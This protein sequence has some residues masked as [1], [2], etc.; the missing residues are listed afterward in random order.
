MTIRETTANPLPGGVTIAT[1]SA[2]GTIEDDDGVTVTVDGAS[3]TEGSTVT[4]TATLSAAVGSNV[5]LGWT[6]G[7]DDTAG[8]RQ[9]TAGT[10]Y[11]AVTS[12]SV[13]IDATQTEASF[14][15]ST[16]SDTATEGDETFKVTIRETTANPLPGGVTIVTASAIG[17]IQDDD[18]VTVSVAD[19][20]ATEGSTVT[21]KATLSGAVSSNVVLGWSTSADDTAG[22]RQATAGTDYTAVT[23]GSVT[24]DATQTEATFTVQTTSDT[25]TEGDETFK[26]TIRETTANPLPGGVTIATASA[27]GTIQDDD[28]VTVTVDGAS[29]T[30]GSTVTFKATLSAAVGSNVVLG[31]TTGADDTSGARQ[32]T[33]GTDYTAVTSGSVTI[34]ATQTEATFTVQTTQDTTTEGDETF[35]VTIRETTA[36]PLPGGVTIVTAS[37]VGTIQDD[38]GVTVSVAD[39]SATEGSTVT[40]KATLSAAV[41]SNVVLGWTTGADDTSG[42]RQATAGTDYTAVTSG[43]VTIVATQTEASFTV[44]TTSDTATEGDETFKVTIRET[45]A[46]PLP[47]GVTIATASAIGTIEDDDGVPVTVDGASATEGSTVTFTATLSAAVGSN[48]VLGWTTGAD[49]TAGARQATAGTDYTAVTSGSV[50]IDATQTEASFTVS[51]TSDTA[52]EGDETFKVTI[53]ETTANPLPGG[54]TIATASAIGTIQDDDGVTVSV[55]DASATEGSTVTFKA[56]LS[57]AV[58]SNV[59][60]GWSTSAD[61][62]AGARQATAGTD[63]TA[64]TN[65]SVTIVATQTEATFTVQ[66]TQDT[67]TEGDETFKVTIGETTANPLPGGVTIA[68]ASAIG[69]IQDDDGVTVSVADASA[70]EGSTVTF[71]ATLSAAVGSNVVLGWTTGADDTSGARQ[72]TAGTDYT[73]VTSGSVTIVATQTEATFT[74][75]TTS[76]TATEGDE[77]FKVT[78]R[79]TTAN[80]LPGGV[81][82]ATASAIGT[83]EDDDGVTVTVD[84]ASAT[85]GSTVTFKATLSAAVG[86]NVVLGWTTGADDTSG[87]RQATAGTDYTAVTNGSVTI[88]ATQTE[89][90]FTVQTTQDTATEGDETFKVTIRETTANPL[91]GGVTIATASAIGTIQD[92]DGVTVSVADA[93]ATEGSTVTFKATLSAAVGSNVVLGWTTGADDTSGARQATAGTDYTAVTSGS[94]TIDATQTE[95]TFTVQTTQDSAT[96]GDETFKVT[97]RETTA[98]PLPG[99]VTIVTGSAIGTI[100]DDD[101]VTVTVDGAS[102]T[103]GSTVTFKATL[104]AAVGSNVVLGWT[105]GADDTS[106]ARQ[107]TAGTDYTAVTSGS[108]TIDATQTEATFTVQTTQDTTTEGDETFKVTIRETTANPLPGGVTIATASAIGTIEDNDGVT[109]TVEGASAVE[110]SAVVF[111][112]T[113][114]AAVGSNVVLGWTTGADDTSGARQ[115]TAGTDYSAVTNGSVTIDANQTEASFMVST[116]QDSATEGDETFK[117]TIRETTANPLPGGVTIVTGSAIGTIQDDDGVTVSVA[118]ASAT[119]GSAVVFKAKLSG[120]VGSSVVLGWTTGA[121]DTTGA[122]QATAGTD[123]A[124]VTS[125]SVTIDANQTEASFTVQTTQDSATEGD[126]TFKVTISETTANPLPGGVTIATAS[127]IGTI[128]DNDG[129]TVT[130]EGAS[131]VEGS[132]VVF[133]ATLSAA[134]GSNVVLGWTTGADDTSGA[135]QATAGTDYSAVTNGS[136]TIDATQTEA[137]FTVSTTSD[138]ATEGD[139]TFKVTIRETTANPLPGGVTIVTA[140]AVGTIQDDDGVTVSVADASATEGSTVTFTVTL[141][142]AV[143]SNVV[144]GWTTGAD[145][146]S[147]ARQATAGTDYTAVTSGSVTIVATQTEATFTVSTTQDTTTE[148]DETFKVTISA[149]TANPLPGGVTIVTASAIGTI[150]D[151]DGVTVSVEPASATEGSTVTFKAKLSAAVGS[152]VVLGWSTGNDDTSGAR[153]ATAGT[154]YTAVTNGSVTIDAN[155]TEASFMVSTA[156][157]ST[158]EGDET[159]KVTITGTTLPGGVTIATASAIGTIQDDDGVTVSVEGAS[160]TEGSTVTFKATLSAAVGS[161]VVL[162]WTTGADDTSGARQATAGTD[163]TAVTSGSVTIDATQTEASFTVSTTSDTATEGDETF[164]VTIRET[165]ANPLPGGVTIVTASAVG[166]IQDDDGVTVSVA[167]ASATE[168]STVTFTVTLSAAVSSNVVLGWTTGADD[169]SGARQATAGTDYTAVTSGSVTIVATQTEATFTVQTTSDT[170]TEG[171]ETFKVT[172]RETTANPLPGGVTIATASAVGTIQDDDGVTVSVAD[173]SATEGSTVT[174]KATLSAAVGSNVV[175]GW[176]T[177]ADDTAG[178]RQ[179]TAGTDY[180]AVTNGSVT[181]V[182]TQTEATFTVQTTQDTTTEGDETFKVTIGETTANPLPGGVTIAT[183]SAIGTIQDDD[184]V[185]V[186]VADASATEGSTVTFKATLSGAV[187]S[188]V[189]LG[190]ST[191]ADDTAGARQATAGTDYTAVTNGS[192]TIVATQTEATFT[193]QTTQDTTTEGDETFKVT[194]GETTANPLPGGV[195]IATA[196]AIG[197]IED[198]DGVTVTVEGASATEGSTVTFTARLSAAVGSNVVLGWTTGADDTAGARQATAGTDYTAVTSGSVTIDATQTEASFTVSTTSDTATEG[199]ET[200]KVTIRETTANPLPG[201]V[202]IATAS[203]VGTIQ[204][205]DTPTA[206]NFSKSTDEDMMLTFAATDFVGAFSDPDGHTLKS[207]KIVTLPDTAHGTLKVGTAAATAGQTVVA[208]SLGTITF[209][210]AANWNGTASFTFKV[211]GSDDEESAEAATVTITVNAV[212]DAPTASN[213]TKAIDEDTPLTFAAAD[214]TGAFSDPDGHTLKSVKIAT[215]PDATHGTLKFGNPLAAAV[216]GDSIAAAD[217]GTITFEPAANWNGTASFTFTVT[218]SS[219]EESAAAATVTITVNAEEVTVSVADASATEGSTVTFKATLSAAVGSN[220]VLGWTTGAD[221]TSGAR[222]ATAGTDYTAVTNGSVTIATTQT[223]ATFTVQT[224]ADGRAEGDETF[225]VT[226][227]ETPGTPLPG[228]VTIGTATAVGTILDDDAA[229]V[230]STATVNGKTLALTFDKNLAALDVAGEAEL[231]WAFSVLDQRPG[232]FRTVARVAVGSPTVTLTLGRGVV[233]GGEVT[234]KYSAGVA[235]ELGAPLRD[236]A[237]NAVESFERT[238]TN[239]TPGT[240]VPLMTAAEVIGSTLTATFSRDLDAASRPLGSR[241]WVLWLPLDWYDPSRVSSGTGTVAVSGKQATV[242]LDFVVP[243]SGSAWVSYEKGPETGPLRGASAGPEVED[244]LGFRA[245]VLDRRPPA[246]VSGNVAGTTVTLYYDEALDTGSTPA[247]SDY[248]VTAGGNAQTVNGVTT[249]DNAVTLTLASAVAAGEAVTVTYTAGTN[250]IRDPEG[251]NAA[252]LSNRPVTNEGAGDPGKPALAATAPATANGYVLTLTYDQPLD[253]AAVPGKEQFTIADASLGPVTDVT[254]RGRKVELGLTWGVTPCAGSFTVRYAKPSANALRNLWG[255]AADGFSGQAVTNAR[256]DRCRDRFRGASASGSEVRLKFD[257]ALNRRREPSADGFGVEPE[258]AGPIEVEDVRFAA[259]PV[260]VV[261]KLRR[262]LTDGERVRVSYRPPRSGA[263]LWDTDGNQ[264]AAFSAEAVAPR[265]ASAPAFEGGDEVTLSIDENNADGAEV[266]RVAA[267]DADGDALTYWLSGADAVHFEIGVAGRITVK[268][269]GRLDHEA[270][271]SYAVTAEVSDGEDAAGNAEQT[272][273][274]DDT[275]AVRIEVGNVEEPPGAPTGMTVGGATV[276]TLAARWTAPADA[277]AAA[278]VGYEVRYQAGAADPG[279]ELAWTL[280]GDVVVETTATITGLA[281]D[282][283]YRVQARARGDGAG[284]WSA[285]G[286]GR[287][288]TAVPAVVEVEV[289]SGAGEDGVYTE[290]EPIVAAVTFSGP[291]RVETAESTPTLALIGDGTIRR[292]GYAWGSGTARLVF[293]YYVGEADGAASAV[294]VAASGLQPGGGA[295]VAAA[296]GTPA[297]LG[298]GAAPG[299]VAVAIGDEPDGRWSAGETVVVTLHFAE[300]VTVAGAPS[301]ALSLGGVERRAAYA[302]GSGSET[303]VFGYPLAETDGEHGRAAVVEDGLSRGDGTIV[304]TGGGL[305]AALGH[306]GASRTLEPRPVLPSLSVADAQAPEGATLAFAVRLSAA[307]DE[308]VT[309]DWATADGAATAGAD[310]AAGSGTLAFAPGETAKTVAVAALSDAATEGEE[311]FTLALSNAQGATVADGEATGTVADVALATVAPETGAPLTAEFIGMPAEHDGRKLFTFE[312]R[313]SEDFPGRLRY[314]LL[315]DEAFEVTGARVRVA[316]RMAQGQNQRWSISVRPASHEDVVV[317]LPA[318]TDCAA[319][320]AVCTEA[321]RRLS[322]A[323]TAT[324]LGPALI[325]VADAGAREGIDPAV[326][327][328]VSLSRAATGEVTVDYGTADGTAKEAE[329]YAAA[330]GRLV[331]AA[332]EREKTIRVPVRND[333]HDEGSETFLLRLWNAQGAVI[334]DGEATGT[335][336]NADAMPRAWLARFGRTLAEQVVAGVQARL[337]APRGDGARGRLAGREL[338]AGGGIDPDQEARLREEVL[339]RWLEGVPEEPRTMSGRELLAGSGFALTA[340]AEE[341]PS[342]ALWG[343]GSLSRFAGREEK[344]SVDG[345][346][347]SVE[348]GADFA[349]GAWLAGV[350]ASHVRGEGSY[351][352]AGGGGAVEST[353]TGVFPYAGVDLSERLT[354]WA[355]AGLGLGGL[356]LTPEAEQALETDLTLALA[357]VG[358]RGRLVEPAAGSGFTLVIETD[359]YWVGTG[360]AAVAGL[361]EAQADATRIRLGLDGGYRF[362]LTGG[363]TLEPTFEIGVRHDGG[364]AETGYGMDLGGGLAW[365]APALG[366]SAELTA[367]G[368]LR[369]E[370][371]GFR[372]LGLAGSLA[373]DPD[374]TSGRG[375]SLTVTQTLG[376]AASGGKHALLGRETLEGLAGLTATDAGQ[377]SRR[378]DIRAGYGFAAFGDRFTATPELRLALEPERREYR[379][380]WRL[381][382]AGRG[383]SAFEIGLEGTRHE[384]ADHTAAPPQHTLGLRITA[385][386]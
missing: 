135:R 116:A 96:E 196:S 243:E 189:V 53:R 360:A 220:V 198:D 310:Y 386:W 16:T 272:P 54:V 168:G 269:G 171:D 347:T 373:W 231:I 284:P 225:K 309:V 339:T 182:A 191:S 102:A 163:Y 26:V 74:V 306:P 108:V 175:L 45:T 345:E 208:A 30:E 13:T 126:E 275:I 359:A 251:N 25:A 35:K 155:Q 99:G 179:A 273:S 344:L 78:V 123:Y 58:S 188:N 93:S 216:V 55:A 382:L 337:G 92:D 370:L 176:T 318:A 144:L 44:S 263:G 104:S 351:G 62:T 177:G 197:T 166:T 308:T 56:T 95:A 20:S 248:G 11:T 282:T 326:E 145:D 122:R 304:S 37:A 160:A 202:T 75:Q 381:V 47:G 265:P 250:P 51:T 350:M 247:P 183:A 368:L 293:V 203:A 118:P 252:N 140:S 324:V 4:F 157:D 162:G 106:G 192:V 236:A 7:A 281:A 320:G 356:T 213:I 330:F 218:D 229:P 367:R 36:N 14:T 148:G 300:P 267:S 70:T 270:R 358:A 138:T 101:G 173:A 245:T 32:A 311:T 228:G 178:A 323:V 139:E 158:T 100:E 343:R 260:G 226:I 97:I 296:D 68:T 290:G 81:T 361:A 349:A 279:T 43:S 12:G 147:G 302:G 185:T 152:N 170:A 205:D 29:A 190:W 40:F 286:A 10:D 207:V 86:S 313:F 63:Y 237:G 332:G 246:M 9:A 223:E 38:D 91:P 48:V 294:R 348:L 119:E 364:H 133:K 71:K 384:H 334:A 285:S 268:S 149:T 254:V 278:I 363:G 159:F 31:W 276:T 376:A 156:Q 298:F 346:L 305:A 111:K 253:P 169:T 314:K 5:V 333:G 289:V 297:L 76:D 385:R 83:I 165:T 1:A 52:T 107:A 329:D 134:V 240:P 8:A 33:A 271:A 352:G 292:A 84:G 49:D 325:S 42:A 221:D 80:P 307:S 114:S 72:A 299:V 353:L 164:K 89:A 24:I 19:A 342:A 141:S 204:D 132:A 230:V 46:N 131:A 379:L 235:A 113:L 321:G 277:G 103:E 335:I 241:F 195:T 59:V 137:S 172:I 383:P 87:A 136:V 21:F 34:D 336:E 193:V 2:I 328:E 18:G 212:D 288:Q 357:A 365:T 371:D 117:V 61:D 331:F 98:N 194:I 354:A 214:F 161:N 224:T 120:A 27:I 312:L 94:V 217:L 67:T 374:P 115:A 146:T 366:L 66:T 317:R 143:S 121:D 199:D 153:R 124:A 219:D 73:A 222:Q 129:V 283:A 341:A 378:L 112:A 206:S 295:I 127:A 23:S 88:V 64:V 125:G 369:R 39:A 85:E 259:D 355:V 362:A 215:L 41:S 233:P 291:V 57:G 6:T 187:S 50:T 315:R 340:A 110:G 60:L 181:I 316:Q 3:A 255:T 249:S 239:T 372:D 142:A 242:T 186:S 201:G 262:T 244:I 69:T 274:A 257:R 322:N 77:T 90:T 184:G 211:T 238:V 227:G 261:L 22:A 234:V 303:L 377:Q 109:V 174:F 375:P 209:E 128:E 150:E 266:G 105:T 151:D 82:I 15:V 327:F 256:A 17:T 79:E 180:T 301:V 28:G 380:G 65:G 154:D 200:F 287:T 232:G 167:D 338:G 210:P 319:A 264:V 130:V 258:A 280:V